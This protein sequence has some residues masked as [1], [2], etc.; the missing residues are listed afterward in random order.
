M[1]KLAL[2]LIAASAALFGVGIVAQ[3]QTGYSEAVVA[4]PSTVMPGEPYDVTY[5]NCIG[6]DTITFAQA[7]SDP[8]TQTAECIVMEDE[9][10][11]DSVSEDVATSIIGLLLPQQV[12]LGTATVTFAAP[13]ESGEYDG[14]ASGLESS[15]L[16]WSIT[17]EGDEEP[18]P[19]TEMSE[20]ETATTATPDSRLP[21][22]GSD[23]TGIITVVA[24]GLLL[25]GVALLIGAQ[26]RRKQSF[27]D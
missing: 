25:V 17:V 14:T 9:I 8:A 5:L 16:P 7:D 27:T 2:A 10:P 12:A 20:D 19:T 13:T 22:T 24:I 6:G 11:T 21:E 15:E 26:L 23:G 18:T 4:E 3:A 1:K